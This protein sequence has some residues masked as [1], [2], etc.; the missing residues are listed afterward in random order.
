VL[1]K[2]DRDESEE[3]IHFLKRRFADSIFVSALNNLRIEI[4][5]QRIIEIIDENYQIVDIQFS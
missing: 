3:H 1:N 4:L 2:I 5:S